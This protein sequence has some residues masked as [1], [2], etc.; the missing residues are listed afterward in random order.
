MVAVA[1]IVGVTG[2]LIVGVPSVG[3][4]A[5]GLIACSE[6]SWSGSVDPRKDKIAN[7]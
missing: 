3:E 7:I 6:A 1:L 4:V 2:I 5:P